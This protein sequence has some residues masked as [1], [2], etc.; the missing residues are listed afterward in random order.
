MDGNLEK[1]EIIF[2]GIFFLFSLAIGVV[3]FRLVSHQSWFN[4]Y[5]NCVLTLTGRDPIPAPSGR[6]EKFIYSIY[7][8]YA[9]LV[10]LVIIAFIIDRLAKGRNTISATTRESID[11]RLE[12]I[13]QTLEGLNSNN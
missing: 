8:L 13:Q 4:S 10:F 3:M 11:Q 2:V 1:N 7:Y 5:Y 9:A 12:I 6:G